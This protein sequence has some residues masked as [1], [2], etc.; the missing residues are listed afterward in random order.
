MK[1]I[2]LVLAVGLIT[3]SCKSDKKVEAQNEEKTVEVIETPMVV[4]GEFDTTAGEFIGK[5]L[6]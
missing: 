2:L 4:L 6:K 5:K 3:F 1:K